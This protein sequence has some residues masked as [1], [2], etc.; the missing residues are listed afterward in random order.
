MIINT[1]ILPIYQ[2]RGI[3]ISDLHRFSRCLFGIRLENSFA[4]LLYL[5]KWSAYRTVPRMQCNSDGELT[6]G[7][8]AEN[9]RLE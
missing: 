1:V 9:L 8:R 3:F 4:H 7:Y 2:G 5:I 6:N